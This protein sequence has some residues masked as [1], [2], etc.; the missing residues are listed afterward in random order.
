MVDRG[1]LMGSYSPP[2]IQMDLSQKSSEQSKTGRGPSSLLESNDTEER[3]EFASTEHEE[4]IISLSSDE[5]K[6]PEEEELPIIQLQQVPSD[7]PEATSP[8]LP[9][10]LSRSGSAIMEETGRI[11]DETNDSIDYRPP[12][13][14]SKAQEVVV[15]DSCES[16]A[17]TLETCPNRTV[18]VSE[19]INDRAGIMP[20]ASSAS[21]NLRPPEIVIT[22]SDGS[23][24]ETLETCPNRTVMLSE[25][26][27]NHRAGNLCAEDKDK[28]DSEN[29]YVALV[30]DERE[31]FKKEDD[32]I[33]E[34]LRNSPTDVVSL[35]DSEQNVSTAA[36][37]PPTDLEMRAAL[38]RRGDRRTHS[39][40][41]ERRSRSRSGDTPLFVI[42]AP[43]T[44][45]DESESDEDVRI[46]PGRGEKSDKNFIQ[47]D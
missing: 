5:D 30:Q 32:D 19:D 12:S 24:I 18:M 13:R 28:S 43:R 9:L 44:V 42:G 4:E 31:D 23:E 39:R 10:S 2:S 15:S 33:E 17:E 3:K 47:I 46:V 25:E 21:L 36:P 29:S 1:E 8:D 6:A 20:S 22:D 7:T 37:P 11:L 35:S 16:E 41:Q 34:L 45:R 40:A 14:R 27:D 26:D 38:R